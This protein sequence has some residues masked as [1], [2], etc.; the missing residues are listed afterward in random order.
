MP[1]PR[2][3]FETD[4]EIKNALDRAIPHGML[5]QVFKKLTEQLVEILGD[6][7]D[8]YIDVIRGQIVVKETE[9]D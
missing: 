3:A 9:N 8:K 6:D 4:E 1:I 2:I 5:K 7:P